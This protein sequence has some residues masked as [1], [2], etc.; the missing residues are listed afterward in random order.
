MQ[1]VRR[2]LS[3]ILVL[4]LMLLPSIALV[5]EEGTDSSEKAEHTV[6]LNIS[7]D[8]D[9]NRIIGLRYLS[10]YNWES[11]EHGIRLQA[12]VPIRC[13]YPL[14]FRC[15]ANGVEMG[16]NGHKM[17]DEDLTI[18]IVKKDYND[19]NFIFA[20]PGVVKPKSWKT[21]TINAGEGEF[22]LPKE[23]SNPVKDI[24]VYVNPLYEVELIKQDDHFIEFDYY[25]FLRIPKGKLISNSL[26]KKFTSDETFTIEYKEMPEITLKLHKKD[27]IT[28][29]TIKIPGNSTYKDIL[30][31]VREKQSKLSED[32]KFV[33]W[34]DDEDSFEDTF[35]SKYSESINDYRIVTGEIFDP[36][37]DNFIEYDSFIGTTYDGFKTNL[38]LYEVVTK[39]ANPIVNKFRYKFGYQTEEKPYKHEDIYIINPEADPKVTFGGITKSNSYKIINFATRRHEEIIPKDKVVSDVDVLE[40]DKIDSKKEEKETKTPYSIYVKGE[41]KVNYI[42]KTQ[43]KLDLSHMVIAIVDNVNFK[44]EYIPFENFEEKG[45]TT[46]PKHGEELDASYN[47]KSIKA[48]YKDNF[49]YTELFLKVKWENELY[50]PDYGELNPL[51]GSSF[52]AKLNFLNEKNT[53]TSNTNVAKGPVGYKVDFIGKQPKEALLSGDTL[54]YSTKKSDAGKTIKIPILV[55]YRDGTEDE[56]EAAIKVKPLWGQSYAPTVDD[57]IDGATEINGTGVPGSTIKILKGTEVIADN[58]PVDSNGNWK[59]ENVKLKFGE[60]ITAIQT[61]KDKKPNSIELVVKLNAP[62]VVHTVKFM[63]N[64]HGEAL[65]DKRVKDGETLEEPTPAPAE[66]GFKFEGWYTEATFEYKYDFKQEVKSELILY[67]KWTVEETVNKKHP[68]VPP[69]EKIE[70]VDINALSPE[71]KIAV[72]AAVKAQNPEAKEVDVTENGTITI[73]YVDGSTNIIKAADVVVKKAFT[74]PTPENPIVGPVDPSVNPNPDESKNWTVTFKADATKVI[75]AKANTFYVLKGGGK[76]LADL[77]NKAPKVEAK[78]GFKVTGW[79]PKLDANTAIDKDL[80]VNATFE[81]V[82]GSENPAAPYVDPITVGDE[83]VLVKAPKDG[84]K[85]IVTLQDGENVEV[86]KS[87]N[88][89]KTSTG[90]KVTVNS[91]NKLEIPVDGNEITAGEIVKVVVKDTNTGKISET[92]KVKITDLKNIMV[93]IE[94]AFKGDEILHIKT[95][96]PGVTVSI[97]IDGKDLGTITTDSFGSFAKTLD[98]KLKTGH[99]IILIANKTGYNEG[100]F[101]GEI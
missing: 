47:G 19:K 52:N 96:V 38:N 22:T 89:W 50:K 100:M 87:N 42:N 71:E 60:N 53:A 32:E 84:D 29:E 43:A 93:G 82:T 63:L 88:E 20:R 79:E 10:K 58:I 8:V 18:D 33:C 37:Y 46:I 39:K 11:I 3:L 92:I 73:T 54:S 45:I 51:A 49:A 77:A 36:K 2:L 7:P 30:N 90:V 57:L 5:A 98:F 95:S 86:T 68:A 75:T 74:P 64:G 14:F 34:S 1:D 83:E 24:K 6:K 97:N 101:V 35:V 99:V 13:I 59:I 69:K 85:I 17:P 16:E 31:Q 62:A 70:V 25:Y 56:I 67:A 44:T 23:G 48:M 76:T 15:Y 12:G 21:V 26:K 66:E 9:S 27:K 81:K 94:T 40:A 61:E 4:A 55:T 65:A 78:T 91:D 80:T 72:K 41:P 28:V